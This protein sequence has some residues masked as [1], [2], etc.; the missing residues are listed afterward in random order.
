MGDATW[1]NY[2]RGNTDSSTVRTKLLRY[3]KLT[4][5]G[6]FIT[7]PHVL[8]LSSSVLHMRGTPRVC[9]PNSILIGLGVL[10]G[11]TVVSDTQPRVGSGAHLVSWPSVVR[12]N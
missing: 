6:R 10:A 4:D 1:L 8:N 2:N 3:F 12:G 7:F 11:I 9:P 5:D